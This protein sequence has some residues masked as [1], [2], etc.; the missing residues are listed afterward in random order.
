MITLQIL[1]DVC[2]PPN[3][4][5]VEFNCGMGIFFHP[6]QVFLKYL[7]NL[8]CLLLLHFIIFT[9]NNI[10][11][12]WMLGKSILALEVDSKLFHQV[13]KPLLDA[14]SCENIVKPSFNLDE[15]FPI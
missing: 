8:L 10:C 9:W 7:C 12:C 1:I 3:S 14:E 2:S 5:V 11:A 13:L 15:D 4:I 6:S